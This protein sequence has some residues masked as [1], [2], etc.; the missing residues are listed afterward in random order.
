MAQ[1]QLRGDTII[2][3]L[4]ITKTKTLT[5]KSSLGIHK[6]CQNAH[7]KGMWPVSQEENIDYVHHVIHLSH[8]AS[9]LRIS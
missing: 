4:Y 5:P 6:E 9:S 1:M 3:V 2:I 7:L 8:M